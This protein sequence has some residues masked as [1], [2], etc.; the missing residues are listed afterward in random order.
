[1]YSIAFKTRATYQPV[2][3]YIYVYMYVCI[4]IERLLPFCCHHAPRR[5]LPGLPPGGLYY[6]Y[7]TNRTVTI[8]QAPAV[9]DASKLKWFCTACGHRTDDVRALHTSQI[10]RLS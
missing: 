2:H 1:M 10:K 7:V 9:G 5:D 4:Y 8:I 3:T 6:E